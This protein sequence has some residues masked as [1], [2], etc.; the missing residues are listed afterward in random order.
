MKNLFA[1]NIKRENAQAQANAERE[2]K[3]EWLNSQ[4]TVLDVMEDLSEK[5]IG[6]DVDENGNVKGAYGGKY[7]MKDVVI[8]ASRGVHAMTVGKTEEERLEDERA[9][10]ENYWRTQNLDGPITAAVIARDVKEAGLAPTSQFEYDG[11]QY[12]Y[13]REEKCCRDI[14]TGE[15]VASLDDIEEPVSDKIAIELLKGRI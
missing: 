12:L 13:F 14:G 1:E 10:R 5:R 4:K 6:L 8:D 3:Q 15:K 9:A 2:N 11:R 7:I